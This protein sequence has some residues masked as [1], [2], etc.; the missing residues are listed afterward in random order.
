VGK[1][2]G[3]GDQKL[4]ESTADSFTVD[5]RVRKGHNMTV[6]LLGMRQGHTTK[7]GRGTRRERGGKKGQDA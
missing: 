1:E 2:Q 7:R 3:S 6:Q 5:K 4:M